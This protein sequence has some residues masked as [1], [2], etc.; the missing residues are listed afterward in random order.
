V[1]GSTDELELKARVGNPA[2]LEA[3]LLRA[4]AE[5]VFRGEMQDRRYDRGGA[6]QA[7]DEVLR[8]RTYSGTTSYGAL[9]SAWGTRS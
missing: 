4:G 8:L 6:L 5:L 7:R 3:A 2:A 9:A 1:S